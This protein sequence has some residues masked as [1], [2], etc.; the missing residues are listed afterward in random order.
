MPKL[1]Q[2]LYKMKKSWGGI[3]SG[4]VNNNRKRIINFCSLNDFMI[5]GALF[6]YKEIHKLIWHSP[7]SWDRNQTDH[8]LFNGKWRHPL[9]NMKITRAYGVC[10]DHHHVKRATFL[11]QCH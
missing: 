5:A 3:G 4:T 9:E 6:P 11:P 7:D 10:K 2:T 8:K 1:E